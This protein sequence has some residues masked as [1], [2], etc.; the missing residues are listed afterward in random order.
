MIKEEMRVL[1]EAV[2]KDGKLTENEKI[3]RDI[4]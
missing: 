3:E 1:E 2:W 4:F